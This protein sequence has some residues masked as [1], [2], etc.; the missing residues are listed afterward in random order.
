MDPASR[1]APRCA[2]SV[3]EERRRRW[4]KL[5]LPCG[6]STAPRAC[7]RSRTRSTGE[8][9]LVDDRHVQRVGTGEP[10]EA[11]RIV[12]L[13]GATIL[14]GFVD[15]H[16]HLTGTGVHHRAP[17]VAATRS[18]AELLAEVR[19]VATGREGP[20]L[21]HGFDE[22]N[23]ADP[24][25]AD[26]GGAR[27]ARRPADRGRPRGRPRDAREQR[28]A[29]GLGRAASAPGL[30]RDDGGSPTGR[31]TQDANQTLRRWFASHLADRDIEELQ[32]A[33]GEPRGLARRHD[34]PRD[35]DAAR[36]RHAG[37]GDPPRPSRAPP[38]RR[39]HLRRRRRT[40][41]R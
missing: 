11:E 14:P 3:A 19:T 15:T 17:S 2:M 13:P 10:P 16:V 18:A 38:A 21:V 37:P 31:V 5:R 36:A 1:R 25:P 30:E 35:V 40:S 34:D 22:S 32:L 29:R 7:T 39:R 20:V 6:P 24:T 41:P 12:D 8:W 28:R 4:A 9:I 26:P 23:W 27:R 33:A